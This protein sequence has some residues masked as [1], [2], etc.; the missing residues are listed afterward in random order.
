MKLEWI[1]EIEENEDLYK[2]FMSDEDYKEFKKY[3]KKT[4]T[5]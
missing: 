2:S 1:E 3:C 5:D 4:K